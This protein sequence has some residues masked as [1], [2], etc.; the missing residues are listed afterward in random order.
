MNQQ[1]QKWSG[2]FGDHYNQR[3]KNLVYTNLAF[4]ANALKHITIEI[5]RIVEFGCGTG[6]NLMAIEKLFPKAYIEGVE[7][8]KKAALMAEGNLG[9]RAKIITDSIYGHNGG[10]LVDLVISKGVL[11][12]QPPNK[13]NDYYDQLVGFADEDGYILMGEY[14]AS[15]EEEVPYRGEEAMMWRRPFISDMLKRHDCLYL[16]DQ[17]FASSDHPL[18][19]QDNITW[20]LFR[21]N[22]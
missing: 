3:N 18:W 11:I 6:Q 9:R 4:F 5:Q 22:R 10:Y 17:G 21:V 1:E 14:W 13:V 15:Q 20:C 8:N 16:I 7:I 2:D 19:P 12:H